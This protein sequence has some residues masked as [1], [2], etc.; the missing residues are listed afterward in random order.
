[1]EPENI[2]RT[3]TDFLNLV[4]I[5]IEYSQLSTH[6]FLPGILIHQGRLIIDLDKLKYSG[7]LLHEAGHIA[8]TPSE[9]REHLSGDVHKCGHGPAEEM[10][11]IAWSWAAC[12]KIGLAAEVLFHPDGYQGGSKNYIE[13][14]SSRGG[15][16]YPLL[17]YWQMCQ[18]D[19]YPTMEKWLRD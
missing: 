12:T 6:T 9:K 14:F 7:D 15:F 3:I 16:G 2:T 17:A 18:P 4:K 10:A 19:S 8:V 11:A 1:M 5:P 13:S